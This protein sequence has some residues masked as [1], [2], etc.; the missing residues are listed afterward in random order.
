MLINLITVISL[1]AITIK[2]PPHL[3]KAKSQAR[4][5]SDEDKKVSKREEKVGRKKKDDTAAGQ[6]GLALQVESAASA[7]PSGLLK[8]MDSRGYRV[9]IGILGVL[10]TV[11]VQTVCIVLVPSRL[12]LSN[13]RA[14]SSRPACSLPCQ[15]VT[16]T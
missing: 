1:L 4:N 13:G 16:A 10:S 9:F 14:P 11:P 6:R 8:F 3:T 12:E 7:L 15:P 5:P 2:F